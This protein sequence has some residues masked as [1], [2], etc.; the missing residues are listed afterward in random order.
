MQGA[1]SG[2]DAAMMQLLPVMVNTY[3]DVLSKQLDRAL[4]FAG[5]EPNGLH[6]SALVTFQPDTVLAKAFAAAKPSG[7]PLLS[8]LPGGTFVLAAGSEQ[9]GQEYTQQLMDL[10]VKP[11]LDAMRASG[12]EALVAQADQQAKMTEV[13]IQLTKMQKATQIGA[14][15]LPRGEN[16]TL[17]VV[18]SGQFSDTAKAYALVKQ[19]IKTQVDSAAAQQPKFKAFLEAVTY[20]EEAETVDGAKVHTLL[21]DLTLLPKLLEVPEEKAA[22][23][24]KVVKVLLGSDGLKA[25]IAVTDKSIIATLG[26][27]EAFL[28]EALVAAKAGKAPLATQPAVVKV[29]DRLPKDRVAVFMV[30]AENLAQVVDRIAKAVGEAGLPFKAGQTS[31]PIAAA[32]VGDPL[33]LHV[34]L[35]VPTDLAVSAKGMYNQTQMQQR[36]A[37]PR[38]GASTQQPVEAPAT[39]PSPEF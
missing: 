16:G 23:A 12:S 35:Y 24:I 14:Y 21:A 1:Q 27:G 9:T 19:N 31:A 38:G 6:L 32:M 30:S 28:K 15:L 7:K 37:Q 26:G 22:E 3:I 13:R 10:F 34:T 18:V 17:G 36:S 8:G 2:G 20:T 25:R 4:I 33:G 29:M 5:L 11:Y 39:A